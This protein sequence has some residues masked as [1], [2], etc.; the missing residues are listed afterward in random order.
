ML[1]HLARIEI[2]ANGLTS[3]YVLALLV[4]LRFVTPT[5]LL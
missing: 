5:T 4:A 1:P 2:G 3:V